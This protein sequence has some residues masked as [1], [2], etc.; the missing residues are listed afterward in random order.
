MMGW[1][2]LIRLQLD[3]LGW[4]ILSDKII[5]MALFKCQVTMGIAQGLAAYD[6]VLKIHRW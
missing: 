4:A 3:S 6:F 2:A 1:E 5:T